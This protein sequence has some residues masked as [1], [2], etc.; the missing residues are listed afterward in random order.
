MKELEAMFYEEQ[1]GTPGLSS[2]EKR[3]L[4]D[5]I[6]L[7][8]FQ[9]RGS[10]EGSADLFSLVSSENTLGNGSQTHQETFSVDR[11]S[12]VERRLMSQ[13]CQCLI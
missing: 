12:F 13:T 9:R 2:L 3:R 5:L 7:Y 8:S 10:G 1:L 6:A 11:T 4:K